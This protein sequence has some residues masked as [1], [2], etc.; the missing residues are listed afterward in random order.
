MAQAEEEALEREL[1]EQLRD[2]PKVH[3]EYASELSHNQQHHRRHSTCSQLS[4]TSHSLLR[5]QSNGVLA[6]RG[7]GAARQSTS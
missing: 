2:R 4:S 6:C 7:G 1:E 3:E 5:P